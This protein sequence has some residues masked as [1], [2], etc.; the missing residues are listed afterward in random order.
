MLSKV[1]GLFVGLHKGFILIV[2][3]LCHFK[4]NS[5]L[6]AIINSKLIDLDGDL[7]PSEKESLRKLE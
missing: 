5:K 3:I 6:I 7:N 2:T 4:F 1:G